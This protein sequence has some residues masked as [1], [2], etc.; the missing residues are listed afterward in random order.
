MLLECFDRSAARTLNHKSR[1]CANVP[2]RGRLR[3]GP[4]GE[5]PGLSGAAPQPNTTPLH[6]RNTHSCP[7]MQP[8]R[9]RGRFQTCPYQ[10]NHPHPFATATHPTTNTPSQPIIQITVQTTHQPSNHHPLATATPSSTTII[11]SPARGRV[12]NCFR[13]EVATA[14][15]RV[16]A[17]IC[18]IPGRSG[19][20]RAVSGVSSCGRCAKRRARL[21]RA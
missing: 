2:P 9:R 18:S 13:S 3:G 19:W 12:R 16:G 8:A 5:G 10:P 21:M 7:T 11:P 4:Q 17:R 6:H 20:F 15:G 1:G 14:F